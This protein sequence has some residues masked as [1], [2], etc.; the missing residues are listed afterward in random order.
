MNFALDTAIM[1][2]AEA[3]GSPP[4]VRLV[5]DVELNTV[6]DYVPYIDR[7]LEELVDQ[8][9]GSRGALGSL[10]SSCPTNR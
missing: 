3:D 9:R 5:A 8:G 7:Y 10:R 2:W 4:D 1:R 6:E